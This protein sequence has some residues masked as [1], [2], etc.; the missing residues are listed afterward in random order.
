MP[1]FLMTYPQCNGGR[2]DHPWTEMTLINWI[3][4]WEFSSGVLMAGLVNSLMSPHI[5]TYCLTCLSAPL[6]GEEPP[7]RVL[8]FSS[9]SPPPSR[10]A[11][12]PA[13]SPAG[14]SQG[15]VWDIHLLWQLEVDQ[16]DSQGN[17][18][19]R[20]GHDLHWKAEPGTLEGD[21]QGG[22]CKAVS[23]SR[24]VVITWRGHPVLYVV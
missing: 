14:V 4:R 24:L 6:A 20:R 1:F 5:K 9:E 22:G 10:S 8:T 12:P 3:C 11:C 15:E 17:V 7:R 18:Y 16:D 2:L 23:R 13:S 19:S 21:A